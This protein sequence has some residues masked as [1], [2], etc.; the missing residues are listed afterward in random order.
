MKDI[1]N[2]LLISVCLAFI[3]LASACNNNFKSKVYNISQS[4]R[5]A[6]CVF[7][8]KDEKDNPI[9][10]WVEKDSSNKKHFFFSKYLKG[11]EK[12]DSPIAIPIEQNATTH[13]EGGPKI[14]VKGN[15]T[16]FA[17]YEISIPKP[18]RKWGIGDLRYVQSSDNG[19]TWT[20]PKSISSEPS[21][22]D[23]SANFSNLIRLKDGEIGITWLGTHPEN[24]EVEM[25]HNMENLD[26]GS[27]NISLGRPVMFSKTIGNDS[28]SKPIFITT[29]AC[30]CCRT[31]LSTNENG[32]IMVVFRGLRANNIRD[33][34]YSISENG[35]KRFSL[36]YSFSNDQW[37]LDACPHAGPSIISNNE[38]IY[39]SWFTGAQKNKGVN[40]ASLESDGVIKEKKLVDSNAKFSQINMLSNGMPI[41]T[42]DETFKKDDQIYSRIMIA[43]ENGNEFIKYEVSKSNSQS[44]LPVMQTL[45]DDTIVIAWIDNNTIFY[46]TL[47]L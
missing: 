47:K 37:A 41:I 4:D 24:K 28:I 33:I 14:A 6:S 19:K 25:N 16:I 45:K 30:E 8:T 13:S 42:F 32:N 17:L 36:P 40:F 7:L 43:T 3:L 31:A 34:T 11:Q 29:S 39:V 20:E 23:L 5:E 46:R 2:Y 10:S 38:K 18:E 21:T 26:H 35:G 15:G 1:H 22:Q 44:R 9:I 12:F 27:M